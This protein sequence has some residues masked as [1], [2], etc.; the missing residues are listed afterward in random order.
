MPRPNRAS[1]ALSPEALPLRLSGE[2]LL[3]GPVDNFPRRATLCTAEKIGIVDKA[4]NLLMHLKIP[5][6]GKKVIRQ[7]P[8]LQWALC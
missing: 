7:A 2:G 4:C 3:F 1:C 6:T 5:L 8:Y